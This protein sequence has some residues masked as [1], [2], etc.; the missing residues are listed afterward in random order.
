MTEESEHVIYFSKF[1]FF[2]SRMWYKMAKWLGMSMV[3]QSD[4]LG[5][6]GN[7]LAWMQEEKVLENKLSIT[8]YVGIWTI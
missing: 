1:P 7:F 5:H 4:A 6:F 2:I 3:T 8:W